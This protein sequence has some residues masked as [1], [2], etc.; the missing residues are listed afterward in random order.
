MVKAGAHGLPHLRVVRAERGGSLEVEEG[1]VVH[2][3]DF[4]GKAE[5][6]PGAVVSS[7]GVF[8]FLYFFFLRLD[9]TVDDG[10]NEVDG[11]VKKKEKVNRWFNFAY[12]QHVYTLQLPHEC[13]SSRRIHVPSMSTHSRSSDQ[14]SVLY[15]N[16]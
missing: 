14:A 9:V 7:V 3:E 15:E 13:S 8:F 11:R 1:V 6:V 10:R 12:L 16:T 2:F 5:A 4:V